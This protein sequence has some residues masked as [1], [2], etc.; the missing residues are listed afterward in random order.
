MKKKVSRVTKAKKK[1]R[2]AKIEKKQVYR[3][4]KER[5]KFLKSKTQKRI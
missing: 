5:I 3:I 2:G 4:T 1:A